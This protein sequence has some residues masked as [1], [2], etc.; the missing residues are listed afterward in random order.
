LGLL[1]RDQTLQQ[2]RQWAAQK[3][4]MLMA[5]GAEKKG[6]RSFVARLAASAR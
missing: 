4:S 3:R 2:Y 1:G 6:A 5:V